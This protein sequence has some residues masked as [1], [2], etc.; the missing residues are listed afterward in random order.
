MK[1]CMHKG[2]ELFDY[3]TK[4]YEL[5][6]IFDDVLFEIVQYDEFS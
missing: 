4:S 5:T 2:V 3:I 6:K 1:M